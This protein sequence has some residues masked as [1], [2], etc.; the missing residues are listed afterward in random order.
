[1]IHNLTI[2]DYFVNLYLR[3]RYQY[4]LANNPK[5]LNTISK[6]SKEGWELT[7]ED[8][9]TAPSWHNNPQQKWIIGEPWGAYHPGWLNKYFAEPVWDG[10]TN[11][12]FEVKF[13]PKEFDSGKVI[14]Y[15]ASWLS[16]GHLFQQ[17]YGRFECRMTLPIGVGVWPAFWLWGP[18]WPPEIDIIEAYGRDTGYKTTH[19]EFNVHWR[20]RG[21]HKQSRPWA[22]KITDIPRLTREAYNEFALE[23]DENGMYFYTNDIKVFQFTNKRVLNRNFNIPG[24]TPFVVI[25]INI[26][27]RIGINNVYED[28]YSSFAVDYIRVYKKSK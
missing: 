8:D 25:N 22:V 7:F 20:N 16:T 13:N 17:Q 1:M 26:D 27:K 24:I 5:S 2:K 9:F 21:N 18:T 19:Q 14:P 3:H 28:Y 10:Y 12:I 4:L 15:S 6:A 23:W 11:A